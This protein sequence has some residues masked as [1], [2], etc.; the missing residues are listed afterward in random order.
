MRFQ[1]L[2]MARGFGAIA[3]GGHV[4]PTTAS[5]LGVVEEHTLTARIGAATHT[6]QLAENE[7]IGRG[8]DDRD[9]ESGERVSDRDERANERSVGA[10]V[11]A[12]RAGTASEHA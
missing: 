5:V 12:T 10:Q 7:R 8:L 3:T 4:A 9:H 1:L 11:D 2:P 6:R